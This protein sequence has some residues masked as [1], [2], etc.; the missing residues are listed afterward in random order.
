MFLVLGTR[1]CRSLYAQHE[2]SSVFHFECL[3][4]CFYCINSLSNLESS[5]S[6]VL[7]TIEH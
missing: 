3:V 6:Q 1:Q 5:K 2:R 7:Y 4:N